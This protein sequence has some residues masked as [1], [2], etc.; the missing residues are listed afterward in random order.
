MKVSDW[1]LKIKAE[2]DQHEQCL[3]VNLE[4]RDPEEANH[5]LQGK[6]DQI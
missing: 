5:I 3:N 1:K 4:G 6:I 2:W